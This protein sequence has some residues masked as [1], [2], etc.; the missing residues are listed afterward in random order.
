M[1]GFKVHCGG[2]GGEGRRD[3]EGTAMDTKWACS[4][5]AGICFISSCFKK[6]EMK[7]FREV[8]SYQNIRVRGQLG[9]GRTAI[10]GVSALHSERHPI[11]K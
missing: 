2:R 6:S 1:K 11:R 4:K 5:P 8:G 3:H 10:S 9:A 7:G